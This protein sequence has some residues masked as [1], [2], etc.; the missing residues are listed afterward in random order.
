MLVNQESRTHF[1]EKIKQIKRDIHVFLI[2]ILSTSAV[3]QINLLEKVE[4]QTVDLCLDR[5]CNVLINIF[6]FNAPVAQWNG[7]RSERRKYGS[8]QS[9]TWLNDSRCLARNPTLKN[10][11]ARRTKGT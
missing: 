3:S 7:W 6:G 2:K 9:A 8:Y 1:S 5:I 4:P 10:P 11:I